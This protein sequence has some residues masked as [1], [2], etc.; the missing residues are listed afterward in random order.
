MTD[1]AL[2][3]LV[4]EVRELRAAHDRGN[5]LIAILVDETRGLRADLAARKAAT[6]AHRA[7][8]VADLAVLTALLPRIAAVIGATTC[9]V[10]ALTEAAAATTDEAGA[11]RDALNAAALTGKQLGRLFKRAAEAATPAAGFYVR[12]IGPSRDGVIFC[13]DTETRVYHI[14]ARL[15]APVHARLGS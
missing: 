4:S 1:P 13:V 11:L 5:A 8:S 15:A 2:L 3:D 12:R 10:R 7:L 9:T 6:R 14:D